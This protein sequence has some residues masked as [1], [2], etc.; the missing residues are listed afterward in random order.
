MLIGRIYRGAIIY[1]M[2]RYY[3]EE[4]RSLEPQGP[5][6]P[7]APPAPYPNIRAPN[8]F[9]DQSFV[10]QYDMSPAA[11]EQQ[12]HQK[13]IDD[14]IRLLGIDRNKYLNA[15]TRSQR[16]EIRDGQVDV[17]LFLRMT[18]LTAKEQAADTLLKQTLGL[19]PEENME[20]VTSRFVSNIE[21][22]IYAVS[23]DED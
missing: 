1:I 15:L 17:N 16:K 12:R 23:S 18:P 8:W 20:P 4:G 6:S 7:G 14:A 5:R 3:D 19:R 11:V 9:A 10:V 13:K 2:W 21:S 22:D